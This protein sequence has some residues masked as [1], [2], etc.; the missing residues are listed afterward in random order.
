LKFYIAD[1]HFRGCSTSK[2]CCFHRCGKLLSQV[3]RVNGLGQIIPV[4]MFG[5]STM[6]AA[7][8][9]TGANF[10]TVERWPI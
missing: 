10:L 1:Y 6:T 3:N 9:R 7:V 5:R 2:R 8:G 4:E